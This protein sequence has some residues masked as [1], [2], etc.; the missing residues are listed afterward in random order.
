VGGDKMDECIIAY[1]RRN[2]NLLIG[3]SSA[4]RIKKTIGSASL[5]INEPE[6]RMRIK[7]RDLIHGNPKELEISETQIAESLAEP[8]HSIVEAVKTALENTAP[9][10]AADLVEKGIVLTGGACLLSNFDTVLHEA[11]GLPVSIAQD[12]LSCVVL[13]TGKA[14][15]EIDRLSGVLSSI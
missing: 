3:E 13:G 8:V 7:G 12:P 11:T 10:L 4:E 6:R 2:Y 9:E 1:V 15:E 14:L 5:L